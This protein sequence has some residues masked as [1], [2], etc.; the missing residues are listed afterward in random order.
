MS[1][2]HLGFPEPS[3]M[4]AAALLLMTRFVVTGCPL[5]LRMVARQ[6]EFLAQHPSEDVSPILREMCEKL[7]ED[8][9]NLVRQNE[10]PGQP[11]EAKTSLH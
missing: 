2:E 6:L 11:A 7:A 4:V 1:E 9:D 3:V 10:N 5:L 8:W